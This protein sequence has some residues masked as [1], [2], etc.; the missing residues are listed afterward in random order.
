MA[1]W[2][3]FSRRREMEKLRGKAARMQEW[4][5][6]AM[7][8]VDNVPV[9]VAWS[10]AQKGFEITYLNA[11]AKAMLGPVVPGGLDA[12]VGQKL[13]ALFPPLAERIDELA[14]PMRSPVR[15]KMP[16]GPLV[17]DLQVVAIKNGK[18]VHTGGMAVWTDVTKQMKLANDFEANVKAVVED[19]ATAV[20]EMQATTREMAAGAEQAKQRSVTVSGAAAHTTENVETMAAAAEQLSASIAEI[21]R[22]VA[23]SAAIAGKAAEKA[24]YTDST[25]QTLSTAA[26]QIGEVVALIQS[27]ANQTNLL[28]LNATIE[29]ARAGEAGK[30]FAIV[31]SEV[32]NLA[33][34]T[35][36][37]TD[38]IRVHI[39]GVQRIAGDTV[40][41]IQ[42]I[43]TTIAEVNEIATSIASAVEE[44]NAATKEIADNVRRAAEGT[45]Q[46]SSNI[47]DVTQA[48]GEVG[49]AA[50]RMLASVDDLSK[51]SEHLR[52]E[53][54]SFLASVRSA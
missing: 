11:S 26:Q 24:N 51:R 31:A 39:E 36:K 48:S 14:D 42:D 6:S 3:P 44:Q 2:K 15:L 38:D 33:A 4:F 5:E 28:A 1:L 13:S 50:T 30:G 22:Q 54:T 40:Q 34:Q 18:G 17:L 43:G 49:A 20:A 32:K 29:A 46:V 35:A 25:V 23:S 16:L 37:A 19:V 7:V 27:I 12:F 9:G 41:T 45:H 21:G 10:D 52:H 53:V 47:A 8:M